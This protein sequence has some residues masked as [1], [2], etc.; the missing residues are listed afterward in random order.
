MLPEAC[1]GRNKRKSILITG[2]F[3][4]I[5]VAIFI[6]IV[7][8]LAW[9]QVSGQLVTFYHWMTNIGPVGYIIIG[10]ILFIQNYPFVMGYILIVML[11]GL[12][13]GFFTGLILVLLASSLGWF[14]CFILLRYF[15]YE[16]SV[17]VIFLIFFPFYF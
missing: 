13:Y 14:S 2:G 15:I 5:M 1:Q 9:L 4:L 8:V 12:L 16:K 17:A 6:G 3:C 7:A 10:A 11:A